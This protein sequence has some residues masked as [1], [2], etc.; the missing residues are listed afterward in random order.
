MTPG[1]RSSAWR[2][3]RRVLLP[4]ETRVRGDVSSQAA[5][6]GTRLDDRE[7]DAALTGARLRVAARDESAGSPYR[8]ARE[9]FLRLE[10]A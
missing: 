8:Y 5:Y 2:T 3:L 1:L 10:H 6:R 9:V 4:L 7:L